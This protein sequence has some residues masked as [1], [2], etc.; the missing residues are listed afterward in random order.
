MKTKIFMVKQILLCILPRTYTRKAINKQFRRQRFK[1]KIAVK[2]IAGYFMPVFFVCLLTHNMYIPDFIVGLI[3][4]L[5]T[6]EDSQV[7][8]KISDFKIS[9]ISVCNNKA[10]FLYPQ[11]NHYNSITADKSKIN[12]FESP[13]G[14]ININYNVPFKISVPFWH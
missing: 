2:I 3:Q 8:Y 14:D 7:N 13:L 11:I 6:K 5:C 10:V 1:A 12:K 4:I 9:G